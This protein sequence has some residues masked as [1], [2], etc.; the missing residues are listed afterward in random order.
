M[1]VNP[2]RRTGPCQV[3]NL[4]SRFIHSEQLITITPPCDVPSAN[5]PSS[6]RLAPAV[7]FLVCPSTQLEV[8]LKGRKL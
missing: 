5:L 8:V 6:R 4:V 1:V 3:V 2:E 7:N